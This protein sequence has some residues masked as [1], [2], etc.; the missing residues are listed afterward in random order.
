[1]PKGYFKFTLLSSTLIE[2]TLLKLG[3]AVKNIGY[4]KLITIWIFE[5]MYIMVFP[6]APKLMLKGENLAQKELNLM[7][8][9]LCMN[10]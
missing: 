1:M 2:P 4:I 7:W 8:S 6:K 5:G 10:D 3:M 9:L